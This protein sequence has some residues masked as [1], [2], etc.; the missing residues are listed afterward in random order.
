MTIATRRSKVQLL[1]RVAINRKP[2]DR[3]MKQIT[4][5]EMIIMQII[6]TAGDRVTSGF[7]LGRLPVDV[8]WKM[9]TVTTFLSRL[10]GRGMLEIVDKQGRTNFYLPT[11]TEEE[12]SVRATREIML[13]S[14]ISSVKNLIAS[15]YQSQDINNK[16]ISALK[17]WLQ[18]E[19]YD[20]DHH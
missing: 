15:L 16:N 7:V 19:G 2:G 20:K 12:Y 1:Q 10:V 5:S 18:E 3:T 8:K 6:W 11:M 9:T 17:D 13:G 4:E 14:G